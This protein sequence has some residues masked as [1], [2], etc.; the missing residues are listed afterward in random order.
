MAGISNIAGMALSY[1]SMRCL[2]SF[3]TFWAMM[4]IATSSR[5]EKLAKVDSISFVVVSAMRC[6]QTENIFFWEEG[7]MKLGLNF[8]AMRSWPLCLLVSTMRKFVFCR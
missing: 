6:D 4:M 1:R 5:W 3:A 8:L 7:G 2:I